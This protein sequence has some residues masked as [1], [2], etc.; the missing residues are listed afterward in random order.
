MPK[1]KHTFSQV[2]D[3]RGYCG[4]EYCDGDCGVIKQKCSCGK[5]EYHGSP[6]NALEVKHVLTAEG[7]LGREICL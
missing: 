4:H 6:D 2:G 5:F 3:R 7:L 1:A